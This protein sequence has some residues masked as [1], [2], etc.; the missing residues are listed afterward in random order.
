M[1]DVRHVR[2]L[3]HYALI[4][5]LS[6]A[7]YATCRRIVVGHVCNVTGSFHA[8]HPVLNRTSIIAQGLAQAQLWTWADCHLANVTYENGC[9][10]IGSL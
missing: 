5:C 4:G 3:A 8:N 7:I 9:V 10:T 2:A 6:R 1:K